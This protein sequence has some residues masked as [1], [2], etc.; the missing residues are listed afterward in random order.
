MVCDGERPSREG[1]YSPEEIDSVR[2]VVI[3]KI[4]QY[5]GFDPSPLILSESLNT[6]ATL[7]ANTNAFRGALYG[8]ASHSMQ[9]AFLRHPNF[10]RRIKNLWFV[11]GTVHPGGGIPLCLSSAKIAVDLIKKQSTGAKFMSIE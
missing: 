3:R 1:Q 5:L 9:S 6:P 11:G 7:A 8:S 2:S 4:H 10:S